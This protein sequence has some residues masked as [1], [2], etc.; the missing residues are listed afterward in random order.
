MELAW[1]DAENVYEVLSVRRSNPEYFTN[2][3]NNLGGV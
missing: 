2:L 1:G 3:Q